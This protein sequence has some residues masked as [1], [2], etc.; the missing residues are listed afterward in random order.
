MPKVS[1]VIFYI[2][3]L[4]KMPYNIIFKKPDY[5]SPYGTGGLLVADRKQQNYKKHIFLFS[6][7]L[8]TLKKIL[9]IMACNIM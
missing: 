1:M 6:K 2:I 7:L 8:K 9:G 5:S 4:R 3:Y